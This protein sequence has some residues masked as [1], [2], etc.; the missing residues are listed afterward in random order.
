MKELMRILNFFILITSIAVS[1][2]FAE[3]PDKYPSRPVTLTLS[4]APGGSAD[5]VCRAIAAVAPKYF[6]QP[7]VIVSKTGGGG[8]VALQNL[9]SS[10]PDGYTLHFGRTGDMTVAPNVEK[11][12]FK[13]EEDFLPVANVV[14]NHIVFSVNAKSPWKKIEDVIEAAKKEPGKISFGTAGALSIVRLTMERFCT[15]AGIKL[16][17]VPFKGTG[18]SMIA[19]MGGHVPLLS[20]TEA[21]I[22]PHVQSGELR[23]LMTCTAERMKAFP[24]VPCAREK[25]FKVDN[26]TIGAIFAPKGTPPAIILKLESMLKKIPEDKNFIE[27]VENKMGSEVKFISGKDFA[28]Y[29]SEDLKVI[30]DIVQRVGLSKKP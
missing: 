3:E 2:L 6:S 25:G 15:E 18:E 22:L 29:W 14:I 1:P 13:M 11:M 9:A 7:I 16:N 28:K 5:L 19:V 8:L 17:A 23:V 30:G 4:F 10:K 24:N 26:V 12:P 20:S 21:E 27:A